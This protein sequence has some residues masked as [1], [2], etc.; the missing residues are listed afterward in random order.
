MTE[1]ITIRTSKVTAIMSVT[2]AKDKG[3]VG[4]ECM[5]LKMARHTEQLSS[6]M[7]LIEKYDINFN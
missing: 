7:L 2:L 4:H 5:L 3:I 6:M 1:Q